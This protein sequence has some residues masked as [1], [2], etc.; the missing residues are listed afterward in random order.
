MHPVYV[1]AK[2]IDLTIMNQITVWMRA[3]PAWERVRTKTGVNERNR[4]FYSFVIKIQ[5]ERTYL[6]SCQHPFVDD[7]L[8]D[9]LEK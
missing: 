9:K 3:F 4:R 2:R 5:V 7:F 8:L 6:L 1:A